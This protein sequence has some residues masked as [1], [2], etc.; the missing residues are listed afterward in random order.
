MLQPVDRGKGL[1]NEKAEQDVCAC[2]CL[3]R[4]DG[5]F[6]ATLPCESFSGQSSCEQGAVG[7][8]ATF[9]VNS[10]S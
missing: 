7:T 4:L 3:R 5:G 2:V 1:W 6:T 10:Q 9:T 8:T